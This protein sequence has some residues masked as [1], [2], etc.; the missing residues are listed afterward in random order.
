MTILEGP[1]GAGKNGE[2]PPGEA[3]RYLLIRKR[4]KPA[5]QVFTKMLSFFNGQ[6]THFSH[7]FV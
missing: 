5:C 2:V 7:V 1:L 6:G 3:V 4:Q